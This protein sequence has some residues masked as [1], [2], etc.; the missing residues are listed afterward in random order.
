MTKGEKLLTE[1][2]ENDANRK[3]AAKSELHKERNL[4]LK[5][6][7]LTLLCVFALEGSFYLGTLVN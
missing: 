3:K 7:G 1:L 4:K 2:K 6:A 5:T